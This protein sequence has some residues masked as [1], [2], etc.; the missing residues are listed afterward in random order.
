M[1]HV[2]DS[3]DQRTAE[4]VIRNLMALELGV[5]LEK[6]TIKLSPTTRVEIDAASEDESV[7][8]EIFARQGSLKGGQVKKVAQ[9]ALKLITLKRERPD[10]KLYLAFASA[11]A[12][13]YVQNPKGWLTEALRV[14]GVHVVVVEVPE[15]TRRALLAAQARQIMSSPV[16]KDE[17]AVD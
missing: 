10:A 17:S 13:A 1:P 6:T 9:D 3:K 5:T 12:A 8:V 15:S 7:L 4:A 11:E 2:A 16:V 14:W